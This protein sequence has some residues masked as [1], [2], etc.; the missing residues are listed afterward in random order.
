[1]KQIKCFILKMRY[2]RTSLPLQRWYL[3][4]KQLFQL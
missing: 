3:V 4:G 2:R 1:M